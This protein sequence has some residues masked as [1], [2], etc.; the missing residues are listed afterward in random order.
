MVIFM[1]I[2]QINVAFAQQIV[3]SAKSII[4]KDINFIDRNGIIIASTDLQRVGK[5]HEAGALVVKNAK[6]QQV[7]ENDLYRGTK[8][9]I[10]YPIYLQED[11]VGVIGITG[12]PDE[13]S[14]YGFLLTKI[15][16][17]FLKEYLLEIR[18]LTDSQR[19]NRFLLNLLYH[20]RDGF[21]ELLH[22]YNID[23]QAKY[24]IVQI[25]L[26][27]RCNPGNQSMIE[28]E[29]VKEFERE[30]VIL[31]TYIYPNE[32]VCL[33][34]KKQ[35]EQL[36]SVVAAYENR[37]VQLL[38]IGV[39]TLEEIENTHIS[40]HFAKIATHHSQVND[41]FLTF[42][43]DM[44]IELLLASIREQIKQEY[45]EKIIGPLDQSYI[46]LLQTYFQNDMSL[47]KTS[48]DLF[49]HKNTLQ[50][51]LLQIYEKTGLDPRKFKNAVVIYL[52]I[53]MRG[54]ME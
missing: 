12:E 30:K 10:N 32:L 48:D 7:N 33:I 50:Y 46:D 6:S 22:H 15:C 8:K 4:G 29:L 25:L 41:R 9:G 34:H 16:E 42:S 21:E 23:R 39:G 31:Y 35:Y 43:E 37:Y 45:Q 28:K 54:Y 14:K 2:F 1:A 26:N 40:Y 11:V 18:S 53:R 20:D 3:D 19:T 47:K 52:A 13:V 44:N 49:I 24:A 38:H 17:I 27:K 36:K 5:Y 51:H